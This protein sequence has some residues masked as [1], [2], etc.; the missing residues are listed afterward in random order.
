MSTYRRIC[1]L[2]T[3]R[4]K[5]GLSNQTKKILN[6][7]A[8]CSTSRNSFLSNFSTG[9]LN[10]DVT[11]KRTTHNYAAEVT[12]DHAWPFH[13]TSVVARETFE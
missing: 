11:S 10:N 7:I 13:L 12:G 8:L 6:A 1:A 3:T 5:V 4:S 2:G 9:A